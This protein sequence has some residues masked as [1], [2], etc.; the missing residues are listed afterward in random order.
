MQHSSVDLSS[1]KPIQ[2]TVVGIK[3]SGNSI[4]RPLFL[5]FFFLMV[6]YSRGTSTTS[7]CVRAS[8]C[9]CVSASLCPCVRSDNSSPTVS[10]HSCNLLSHVNNSANTYQAP[11][12]KTSRLIRSGVNNCIWWG[13]LRG[14][15]DKH[16]RS[17][18]P[19]TAF[20]FVECACRK[21]FTA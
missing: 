3:S 8:L 10:T 16:C 17:T 6:Y 21:W 18:I 20:C 12:P 14:T 7:P 9:P 13:L 19:S 15:D 11:T 5:F 1:K 4:Y 2:I